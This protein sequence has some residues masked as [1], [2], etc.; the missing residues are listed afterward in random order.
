M[1]LLNLFSAFVVLILYCGTAQTLAAQTVAA[2]PLALQPLDTITAQQQKLDIKKIV[3][4][5][6]SY[7]VFFTDSLGNRTSSADIW[8][9]EIRLMKNTQGRDVYAFEWK[10]WRK[11][12][13]L[14]HAQ[15]Q[16]AF[17]SLEILEYSK[18][19]TLAV[20]REGGMLNV[21]TQTR[22]KVDTAFTM[23]FDGKA[24]AFPM[25]L[26]FFGVLPITSVGQKF[27]VPFYEPGGA[28]YSYYTC[29]VV[30]KESLRLHEGAAVECWLFQIDYG[31]FG[32]YATFWISTAT[33]EVLKMQEYFR[34]MYRYKIKLF[35]D[36]SAEAVRVPKK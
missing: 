2:Q 18:A 28:K 31:Q 7:A 19:P 4:I 14:L 16:C 30:G 36:N 3:P 26:E 12:S 35:A 17:P 13:L 20:K 5:K 25:D 1:N 32:S 23:A 11:D 34:G 9:R 29:S 22:A 21:K 33:G 10:W 6:H 27:S 8:D 24:F 15:G